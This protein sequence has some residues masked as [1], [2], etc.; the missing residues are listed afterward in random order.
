MMDMQPDET[1]TD[2][3]FA[4]DPDAQRTQDELL[5]ARSRLG[6]FLDLIPAGLLIHQRH[7]IIFA[8][9]EA[10]N[11]IGIPTNELVGQGLSR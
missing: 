2:D 5:I 3:L 7:A 8:N 1:G 4:T 6:V 11:V 10:G 9:S